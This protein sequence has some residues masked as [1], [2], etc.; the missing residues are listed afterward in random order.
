MTNPIN[1][2]LVIPMRERLLARSGI[3]PNVV[4]DS[5]SFEQCAMSMAESFM[6]FG[7]ELCLL[8]GA[9]IHI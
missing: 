2:N 1:E 8:C 3:N 7:S 6:G 4:I 9:V 5:A